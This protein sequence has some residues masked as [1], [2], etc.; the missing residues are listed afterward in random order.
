MSYSE[1]NIGMPFGYI[2]LLDDRRYEV[3]HIGFSGK[4]SIFFEFSKIFV[5]VSRLSR[6]SQSNEE[7]IARETNHDL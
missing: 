1:A 5:H 6:V 2:C 3:K 4:L 7:H